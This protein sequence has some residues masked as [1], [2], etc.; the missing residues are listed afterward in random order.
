MLDIELLYHNQ[1]LPIIDLHTYSNPTDALEFL[2]SQLFY[3]YKKR[4][5]QVRVIHGVGEG[6]L[7]QKVH[8][9]LKQNALVKRFGLEE[10]GGSTIVVLNIV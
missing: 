5:Q 4:E 8:E 6:I 3:L 10:H 1:N 7:K 2:E 9:S